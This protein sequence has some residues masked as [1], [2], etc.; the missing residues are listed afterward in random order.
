MLVI[1][2]RFQFDP[3]KLSPRFLVGFALLLMVRVSMAA[4]PR[5]ATP[6]EELLFEKEI[7]PLL[8]KH[9]FECHGE[10]KQEYGLR[11]DRRE[12]FLKGGDEG[13]V[14]N[15]EK[16][17]ESKILKSIRREGDFP[18]PPDGKEKLAPEEISKLSD[19]LKNGAPWPKEEHAGENPA[20][21]VANHWAFQ[22][23][24]EPPVP[25][26]ASANAWVRTP[27]DAFIWE[28]LQAKNLKP[29]P[30]ADPRALLRRATYDVTGL[31]P[32]QAELDEFLKDPSPAAYERAVDRLLA[33]P[34]YGERWGRYW[35][36]LARYADTKGYV[37][38]EDRA[39]HYA[40]VYRDWVIN[41][42]N[43]DLP[44]DQFLLKQ[45][46][47]DRVSTDPAQPDP[48][49]AAQG[50]LT[51][52]RRFLNNKHDIIDD[53]IDV[54]MRTT[55]ALT[56]ACARC[57]DH[58]FDPI[59]TADYYSLYGVFDASKE[60]QV[61]LTAPSEEY[62]NGL[63]EREAKVNEYKDAELKKMREQ[64]R[65]NV[66]DYLLIS[67]FKAND[68]SRPEL[69]KHLG[70]L[71]AS[72]FLIERW[73][74]ELERLG[75][76]HSPVFAP[77]VALSKLSEKD[78]AAQAAPICRDIAAK[79][80]NGKPVNERIANMFMGEVPD[81]I[82]D[83][84]KRYATLFTD[85]DK[86]WQESLKKAADEK[87]PAPKELG[88]KP[89]EELRRVLYSDKA[90]AYIPDD[91]AENAFLKPVKD[92]LKKLRDEVNAWRSSDKAPLQALALIDEE[93][94][95]KD[96]A[97][98]L[99]GNPGRPGARVPRQFLK[100]VA[101]EERKPFSSGSGR[102]ELARAIASP[103]NPLTARVMVNRIWM[104]YLG[105]GLVGTGSDFGIRTGA[106]THPELLD[107]MAARF[108]AEGWS[109]KK[110]QRQI[111]LSAVYQQASIDRP[112]ARAID[113]ENSL[114]WRANR[115]RLDLEALR[116][117]LLFVSGTLDATMGGPSVE[118]VNPPKSRR[119]S[120]YGY[121][122]RQNLPGF[123]RTFD[124]ASP[125]NHTSQRFMTT[126]PQQALFLL[127]SPFMVEMAAALSR[128]DD[129]KDIDQ[130][131]AKVTALFR[132]TLGREP[133]ADELNAAK[134]FLGDTPAKPEN[135]DQHQR[136]LRLAQA[137]LL[138]NEF[139]FVD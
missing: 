119:R 130:V 61:P 29:S 69:S 11:L 132:A 25:A 95:A 15:I 120:V 114:L 81:S 122:E 19:W 102:L 85:V 117:S 135:K 49:R 35:L 46:A 104:H 53:R 121:I 77:W 138:T 2:D 134:E 64:V 91:Q 14:F 63:K 94:P 27:I 88:D 32:S 84:A 100:V 33:S 47:A 137:L 103:E 42:L 1:S 73:K 99:R 8:A 36:D 107:Y 20:K 98:L 40:Y 109:L 93:K 82:Q 52:G 86:Q 17:A 115:R 97:I 89:T 58:K 112:E 75:K 26:N 6:G 54:V 108:V 110:L 39:Y 113:S 96:H 118:M 37:F 3:A 18:M 7:R 123:F 23:V 38:Q 45:L 139:A 101:G 128:R 126:V 12:H 5:V 28:K 9:C 74:K 31:P 90:V 10:K 116:D 34:R 78:F 60:Q 43:Q 76:E 124:F 59:P 70:K 48:D 4:E 125:D 72:K 136:W 67:Q 71:N 106:P 79:T 80:I 56:V 22:P 66:G 51:L 127:N 87:Q 105:N 92:K 41:A 13:K 55:Q 65:Q 68:E 30:A 50:F 57:H 24:K 129:L 21:A 133:S 111:L 16:P 62:T 131:P 44:Y 83:V